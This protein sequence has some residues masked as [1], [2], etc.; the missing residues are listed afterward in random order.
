MKGENDV[1]RCERERE[2]PHAR[3]RDSNQKHQNHKAVHEQ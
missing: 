2:F 1:P 3:R